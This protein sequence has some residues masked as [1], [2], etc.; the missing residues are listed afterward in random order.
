MQNL[1][2]QRNDRKIMFFFR[3]PTT[4]NT[5]KPVT[6]SEINATEFLEIGQNLTMKQG[7]R[8]TDRKIFEQVK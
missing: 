6:R 5:W 8:E 7:Y 3:K 2:N 4:T 1:G